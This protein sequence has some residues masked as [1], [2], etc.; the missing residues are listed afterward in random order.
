MLRS[1]RKTIWTEHRPACK[2]AGI[3]EYAIHDHRHTAAV[4]L[5]KTGMPLHLLQQQLGHAT[6]EMTTRYTRFHPDYGHVEPYFDRAAEGFGLSTGSPG[7]SSGSTAY[8]EDLERN[9]EKR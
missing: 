3:S 8:A 4:H 5:A 7:S 2:I 1:A 6:I 9:A